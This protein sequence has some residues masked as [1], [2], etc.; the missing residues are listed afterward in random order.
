M[1]TLILAGVISVM[2]SVGFAEV[3]KPAS[4]FTPYFGVER[5]TKAKINNTFIGTTTKFGDLGVT[6]QINWNN[7]TND[8]NMNHEGADL[9]ISYG[10]ADTVSL[11]LKNDFNT[12][13]EHTES[14]VGAKITF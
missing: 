13:F 2:A 12:D 9:D 6:G 4:T 5:E 8:L 7:T 14:T 3:N 10:V 11:Y 1:K